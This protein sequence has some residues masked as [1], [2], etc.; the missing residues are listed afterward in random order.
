VGRKEPTPC[1][2]CHGSGQA[3]LFTSLVECPSCDGLGWWLPADYREFFGELSESNP[4]V[5]VAI[6]E[7]Y[8][9]KLK[10]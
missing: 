1:T 7:F 8:L 3:A 5:L 9:R 4:E 10:E 6:A 2:I